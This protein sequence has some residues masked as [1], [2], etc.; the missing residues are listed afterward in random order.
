MVS[1]IPLMGLKF[2]DYSYQNNTSKYFLLLLGLITVIVCAVMKI[3]WL[4]VPAIF[5]FYLVLSLIP[6]KQLT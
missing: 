4:A 6:K 3:I 2:K 5:I 1:N